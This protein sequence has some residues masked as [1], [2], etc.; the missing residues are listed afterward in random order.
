[1][2]RVRAGHDFGAQRLAAGIKRSHHVCKWAMEEALWYV[3]AGTSGGTNRVRILEALDNRP[4]NANQLAA[5]LGLDYKTV[6]HHLDVLAENDMVARSG[7]DYGAVYLPTD[8]IE[9]HWETVETIAD[10]IE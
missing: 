3:L 6:R 9:Y 10:D 8:R 4:R 7:D 5:D 2:F 1:M